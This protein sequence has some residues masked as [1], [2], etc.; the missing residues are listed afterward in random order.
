VDYDGIVGW[1]RQRDVIVRLDFRAGDFIVSGD[2]RVLIYPPVGKPAK[3]RGE[4][5]QFI[6]SGKEQVPVQDLEFPLRHLVEIALRALSPGMNDP[7]TATAV[8]DQLRGALSRAMGRR[9]RSETLRDEAGRARVYRQVTTYGGLLDSAFHQIRQAGS[10]H[11][12]ILIHMLEAIR[13]IAEHTRLEE[14]R[15]ALLRHAGLIRAA[16]ERDV[17]EAA[18]RDDIERSFRR[19]VEACN[20]DWAQP[21]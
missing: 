14:Q 12:A 7:F 20:R 2:R 10:S 15:K 11:P 4:I 3:T 13:R 21:S 16:A 8:I 6:V 17:P 1:A 18:D 5:G 19:A 9:L